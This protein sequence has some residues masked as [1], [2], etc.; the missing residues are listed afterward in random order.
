MIRESRMVLAAPGPLRTPRRAGG[1]RGG[2]GPVEGKE[3]Q[4]L[5]FK[6][7]LQAQRASSVCAFT[8][9]TS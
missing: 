9:F 6:T 3:D 4:D 7:Q 2:R 5:P 8:V 1:G